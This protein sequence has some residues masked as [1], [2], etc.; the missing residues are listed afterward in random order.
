[1]VTH[2]HCGWSLNLI[3]LGSADK[4]VQ[5]AACTV[6]DTFEKACWFWL[7]R[8]NLNSDWLVIIRNLLSLLTRWA[9]VIVW[10]CRVNR[11]LGINCTFYYYI[12]SHW[13]CKW[14]KLGHGVSANSEVLGRHYRRLALI[15]LHTPDRRARIRTAFRNSGRNLSGILSTHNTRGKFIADRFESK[16]VSLYLW[17]AVESRLKIKRSWVLAG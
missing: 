15:A 6:F 9:V 1:M 3:G 10:Q 4:S 7:C 13:G 16:L 17:S 8:S 11:D 2:K 14:A 12:L 5:Q